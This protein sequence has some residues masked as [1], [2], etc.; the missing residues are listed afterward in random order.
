MKESLF[1][2]LLYSNIRFGGRREGKCRTH[3]QRGQLPQARG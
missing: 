2:M 3:L 1:L